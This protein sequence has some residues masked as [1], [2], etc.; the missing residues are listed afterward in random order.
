MLIVK[1]NGT[2]VN[3]YIEIKNSYKTFNIAIQADILNTIS[4]YTKSNPVSPSVWYRTTESMFVEWAWHNTF[5]I[6][7]IMRSSSESACFDIYRFC[8]TDN[9]ILQIYGEFE[10]RVR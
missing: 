8:T 1:E 6:L 9:V 3:F 2:L 4:K 5:Y 10:K 7:G